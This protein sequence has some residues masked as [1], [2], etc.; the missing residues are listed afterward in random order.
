MD[1]FVPLNSFCARYQ[2]PDEYSDNLTNKGHFKMFVVER[3]SSTLKYGNSSPNLS[4]T[5]VQLYSHDLDLL[6]Q[7]SSFQYWPPAVGKVVKFGDY[8]VDLI[9]EETLEGFTIR[10]LSVLYKKVARDHV[11]DIVMDT[12][13]PH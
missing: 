2:P 1:M 7:E 3:L 9:S 11:I 5:I 12:P 4:E 8:T 6:S 10:T 13:Y